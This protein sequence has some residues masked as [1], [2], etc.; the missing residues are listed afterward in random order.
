MFGSAA[1]EQFGPAAAAA[2][3]GAAPAATGAGTAAT[4]AEDAHK[5]V[6][7]L[8]HMVR[9]DP[10]CGVD[11]SAPSHVDAYLALRQ[12]HARINAIQLRGYLETHTSVIQSGS[13]TSSFWIVP[14]TRFPQGVPAELQY[15]LV[16]EHVLQTLSVV[17]VSLDLKLYHAFERVVPQDKLGLGVQKVKFATG[18]QAKHIVSEAGTGASSSGFAAPA[19]TGAGHPGFSPAATGAL[20]DVVAEPYEKKRKLARHGSDATTASDVE[21]EAVRLKRTLKTIVDHMRVAAKEG[22]W[23]SDDDCDTSTVLFWVKECISA[24]TGVKGDNSTKVFAHLV[25][26]LARSRGVG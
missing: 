22:R 7:A 19:A 20:A 18:T 4:S 24:A 15:A 3:T 16:P 5:A 6:R 10:A 12:H 2:A 23:A 11:P 9:K 14:K 8:Q 21:P 17:G 26:F 1:L 13:V 25:Q